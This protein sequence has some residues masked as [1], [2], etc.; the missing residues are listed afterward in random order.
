MIFKLQQVY[1]FMSDDKSAVICMLIQR[2]K[3]GLTEMCALEKPDD[4]IHGQ[5]QNEFI[6]KPG[7]VIP[8]GYWKLVDDIFKWRQL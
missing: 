2:A 7:L 4:L 8:F 1:S 6:V 3:K 5:V